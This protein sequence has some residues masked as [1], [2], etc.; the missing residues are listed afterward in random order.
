M[1]VN[2]D[3]IQ[4]SGDSVAPAVGYG[5]FFFVWLFLPSGDSVVQAVGYSL[6][7]LFVNLRPQ[8]ILGLQPSS[9]VYFLLACSFLFVVAQRKPEERLGRT[10]LTRNR[11]TQPEGCRTTTFSMY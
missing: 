4:A 5:L 7:S 8:G 6:F 2:F 3:K 1:S 10:D 11:T 9:I